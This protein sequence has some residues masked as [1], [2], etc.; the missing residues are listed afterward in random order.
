VHLSCLLDDH[1]EI[2]DGIA[3]AQEHGVADVDDD[4]EWVVGDL[5]RLEAD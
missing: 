2:A 4:G 3:I 1:P 5:S